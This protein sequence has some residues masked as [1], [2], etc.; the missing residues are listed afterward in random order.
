MA[1]L[2]IVVLFPQV[3]DIPL[4][5]LCRG[6]SFPF[7][8]VS[9]YVSACVCVV[10]FQGFAIEMVPYLPSSSY[11]RKEHLSEFI[12]MGLSNFILRWILYFKVSSFLIIMFIVE[13]LKYTEMKKNYLFGTHPPFKNKT[14]LLHG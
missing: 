3:H 7:M 6:T 4:R 9:V 2:V 14:L 1:L 8:C 5:G 13:H 12:V 10:Y 11:V